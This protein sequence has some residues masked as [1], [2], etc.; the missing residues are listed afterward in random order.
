MGVSWWRGII[1]FMKRFDFGDENLAGLREIS[2]FQ[3]K[4]RVDL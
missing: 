1:D 4:E 3:S 2:I